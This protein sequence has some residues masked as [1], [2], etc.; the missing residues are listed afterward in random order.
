MEGHIAD[1]DLKIDKVC[2]SVGLSRAQLYRKMK[3]LTGY[4]MADLI[5]EVRLKRA[6]QLLQDK[7][8][9]I[10]EVAYMVGFSDPEYFRKSFKSKF[11]YPPSAYAKS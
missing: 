10:S 4:S 1:P 11:G 8:F 2:L 5:K 6:Q 7:K 9:Q 3:A